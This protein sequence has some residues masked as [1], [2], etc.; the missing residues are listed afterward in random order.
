MD[1]F[2]E[3]IGKQVAQETGIAWDLIVE[4]APKNWK[5]D[6]EMNGVRI[7]WVGRAKALAKVL[8]HV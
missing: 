5:R 8:G 2:L 3:Y 1:N 4:T 7:A 6:F